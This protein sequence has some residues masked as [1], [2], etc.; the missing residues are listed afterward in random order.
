M[1]SSHFSEFLIIKSKYFQTSVQTRAPKRR[2]WKNSRKWFSVWFMHP[3]IFSSI[4][5]HFNKY[6]RINS[7]NSEVW[8]Q[9]SFI[10]NL[11]IFFFNDEHIVTLFPP[12][13]SL[14][15]LIN[16]QSYLLSDRVMHIYAWQ[17]AMTSFGWRTAF[18]KFFNNNCRE[19]P[20]EF[21]TVFGI[22]LS[23][24]FPRKS[25][26]T[27]SEPNANHPKR[28]LY[29]LILVTRGILLITTSILVANCSHAGS[30]H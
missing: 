8:N 16:N 9:R 30:V 4:S 21:C 27:D 17:V 6:L 25:D 11:Q 19:L 3:H 5:S 24:T 26:G 29:K 18:E 12:V 2:S 23:L 14:L 20:N 10:V 15:L 13:S 1:N 22:L 28:T 7:S